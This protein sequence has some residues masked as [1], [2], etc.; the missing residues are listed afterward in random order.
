MSRIRKS[1]EDRKAEIVLAAIRLA[2]D[3]G[4]DRLTT[5]HLADAVGITQPA[6]FRHFATKSDIWLAVG[7]Q[8]ALA[9]SREKTDQAI[10]N[11]LKGMI[12]LV[13]Q[14]LGSISRN[15]A[16]PAILF[17]R[18]LHVE[19][20]KLRQ[21]FEILMTSR[22]DSFAALFRKAQQNGDIKPN[23][24]PEDAAALVLATIQGIAMRW[25]LEN[26]A[27]DIQQEGTR[28]ISSLIDGFRTCPPPTDG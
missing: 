2:G 19:N 21:H 11:P 4:P 25:S 24:D 7:E 22:R 12:D 28:L 3:I 16:I 9:L 8:I 26:K 20:D 1:A 23:I 27:F 17:S 14:N 13:S 5:Q 10:A 18:E 6:I 15:P